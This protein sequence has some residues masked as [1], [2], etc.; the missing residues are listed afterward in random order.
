MQTFLTPILKYNESTDNYSASEDEENDEYDSGDEYFEKGQVQAVPAEDELLKFELQPAVIK[1]MDFDWFFN[2]KRKGLEKYGEKKQGDQVNQSLF[3]RSFLDYLCTTNSSKPFECEAMQNAIFVYWDFYKK[4]TILKHFV[5]YVLFF[6]LYAIY[7][8]YFVPEKHKESAQDGKFHILCWTFGAI[9]IIFNFYWTYIEIIQL[10]SDKWEHLKSVWNYIDFG[11]VV[12]TFTHVFMV[13]G[14]ADF[15]DINRVGCINILMMYFKL[16]YFMRIFLSTS[17]LVRMIIET[18]KDMKNFA[19]VVFISIVAFANAFYIIG[20]NSD[21]EDGN[22]A[23]ELFTDAFIFSYRMGLG[24]FITDGF[25]TRD[26]DLLWVIFLINTIII[27]VVLLNLLL[28][29]MGD[30]F[31]R[32]KDSARW[33][34]YQE[35]AQLIQENNFLVTT[36]SMFSRSKYITVLQSRIED[37]AG[38]TWE[39]R[40]NE[41]R[42]YMDTSVEDVKNL[43]IKNRANIEDK[44]NFFFL[45]IAVI[46]SA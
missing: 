16:F 18:T 21:E 45:S 30:T 44:R 31:D 34:M 43:T 19:L 32:V 36:K 13:M 15:E 29:I 27:L 8:T 20:R 1:S 9:S 46:S 35:L 3:V 11:I 2:P 7:A 39:G 41:L 40:V 38:T 5:P 24:D 12:L 6:I 25:T 17:Y 33:I 14:D 10:I 23:G 42:K 37:N 28:A 26:Q 4:V 22:L